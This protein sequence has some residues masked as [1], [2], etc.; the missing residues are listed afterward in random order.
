MSQALPSCDTAFFVTINI[1][2]L[3]SVVSLIIR[4]ISELKR[5]WTENRKS[6]SLGIYPTLINSQV[7]HLLYVHTL[8]P[9]TIL[10]TANVIK[11]FPNIFMVFSLIC[12]VFIW[13]LLISRP[14]DERLKTVILQL[15]LGVN[16]KLWRSDQNLDH[17]NDVNESF[18]IRSTVLSCPNH[19]L[20]NQI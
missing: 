18:S 1:G 20:I 11:Y 4:V 6:K 17:L 9:I 3:L 5:V 19:P 8:L 16:D 2:S 12:Q 10:V 15:G 14:S 7:L 13:F